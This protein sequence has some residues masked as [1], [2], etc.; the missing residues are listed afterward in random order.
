MAKPTHDLT[1][2]TGEYTDSGGNT[3]GRWLRIGTVFK[4][5]DGGVSIKLDCVPTGL[6]E[7]DGWVSVFKREDRSQGQGANGQQFQQQLGRFSDDPVEGSGRRRGPLCDQ[8]L[9]GNAAVEE[10]TVEL[11]DGR[12]VG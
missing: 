1:V 5:D 8:L 4:H 7:W 12:V 9:A 3:K 10:I 2:K 6:P 11:A